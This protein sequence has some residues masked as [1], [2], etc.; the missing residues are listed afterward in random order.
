VA[1]ASTLMSLRWPIASRHDSSDLQPRDLLAGAR[2]AHADLGGYVGRVQEADCRES[3]RS[4]NVVWLE[5]LHRIDDQLTFTARLSTGI[6]SHN[7]DGL[8][9]RRMRLGRRQVVDADVRIYVQEVR[10]V[11]TGASDGGM[12]AAVRQPG[13]TRYTDARPILRARAKPEARPIRR[14]LPPPCRST[15]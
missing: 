12:R 8:V 6:V 5:A 15:G 14:R 1:T 3:W 4:V 9:R 11:H 2:E 13:I 10:A 7:R